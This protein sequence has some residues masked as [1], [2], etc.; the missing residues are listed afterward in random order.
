VQSVLLAGAGVRT[1]S[2]YGAS[3]RLGAF[4]NLQPV[5]P[6]NNKTPTTNSGMLPTFI[7]TP[8]LVFGQNVKTSNSNA[9]RSMK[10][11]SSESNVAQAQASRRAKAIARTSLGRA[12]KLAP[13]G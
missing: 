5:A 1:G 9:Q 13:V 12:T 3:D 7:A 10:L 8:R 2:V 6:A 4:P 11:A